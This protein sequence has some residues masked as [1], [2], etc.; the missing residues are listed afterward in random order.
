GAAG[1]AADRSLVVALGI[2]ALLVALALALAWRWRA[3]SAC[4]TAQRYRAVHELLDPERLEARLRGALHDVASASASGEFDDSALAALVAARVAGLLDAAAASVVRFDGDQLT[5]IGSCAP[6][7]TPERLPALVPSVAGQVAST[8]KRAR[9]DDF[10]AVDGEVARFAVAHGITCMVAVPLRMHGRLW[11]CVGAATVTPGGLTTDAQALLDRFATAVS[12]SLAAAEARRQLQDEARVERAL[13]EV[14]AASS[15]GGLSEAEFAQLVCSQLAGLLDAT[16]TALQRIEGDKLTILGC[17]GKEPVASHLL[18][19]GPGVAARVAATGRFA[20]V[21]DHQSSGGEPAPSADGATCTIG[22]PVFVDGKL[23]GSLAAATARSG[24][25]AP[26]SEQWLERFAQLVC[27]ALGKAQAE[28][29]LRFRARLEETL[30]EVAVASAS[31]EL[32]ER[33]LA[34]LVGDRVMHLLGAAAS[35]VFRFD[36]EWITTLGYCGTASVPERVS[37]GEPSIVA[38]VARTGKPVREDDFAAID[39]RIASSVRE[40]DAVSLGIGVP[41]FVGGKLWG[42]ITAG[43]A[44]AEGF[45]PDTEQALERLAEL[46]SA[47]LANTQAQEQLRERAF[48][49]DSLQDGLVVLDCAGRIVEVNEPFSRMTGYGASELVGVSA[50]YPFST[51]ETGDELALT[52]AANAVERVLARKDT[53]VVRVAASVAELLD[54]SGQSTGRVAA[55][56]DVSESF[57]RARLERALRRVAIASAGGELDVQAL[58]DLAAAEVSELLDA[59]YAAIMRFDGPQLATVLG[60]SGDFPFPRSIAADDAG[61]V[62]AAVAS[63]GRA[64]RIDDY[65]AVDGEFAAVAVAYGVTGAV[66][67]PVRVDG[68]LWGCVGVMTSRAGGFPA[69]TEALL[70]RFAALVSVAF[71]NAQALRLRQTEARVERALREVTAASASGKHGARALFDL[72]AARVADLLDGAASVVVRFERGR[73]VVVGTHAP[74][75]LPDEQPLPELA[76]AS[77][78]AEN[79]RSARIGDDAK[80]HN[81]TLTAAATAAL[82]CRCAV[83]VPVHLRGELWGCIAVAS[84]QPDGLPAPAEQLLERFAALVSVALAQADTLATLQRQANTDGLT[85]LL[86]HRA[87]RERLH[88]ERRRAVRHGRP[89]ALVMFDLDGFKAV[90]DAHG[91]QAGDRVLETVA[92]TFA[93]CKR[94]GDVPARV[95]GDEFAVIAP[96][97]DAQDALALAERLRTAAAAALAELDLPVTLSAG[98]TDLGAAATTGDL[99]HLAD[100]ALYWAKH[101]GRNQ[102]VRYAPGAAHDLSEAQRQQ[103][104]QR[105]RTLTGLGA[106]V[107]AVDAKDACAPEHAQRVADISEALA[108]RLGWNPDRCARLREAA[109]LHDIGKIGVTDTILTKPGK[110][111]VHEYEQVKAHPLLGA[112]ITQDVLDEEQLRWL[113]SHHERPDGRGYPD[114]LTADSIPDGALL[115]GIADA[116]DAMTSGRSYQLARTTPEMLAEMRA[117][118]GTQFDEDLLDLLEG[119]ALGVQTAIDK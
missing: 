83:A 5:L 80:L 91:H 73:G 101:H 70:E 47:A 92:G 95:G 17:C 62:S 118:A 15:A 85:G 88:E 16:G 41:V 84:E 77:V 98:V 100:S 66:A 39:G 27:T 111:T 48:I 22:V 33:G 109:L 11:G 46:V 49:L 103:R 115:L 113:R 50:P 32:D 51:G 6:F 64:A 53:S 8:G 119:W 40:R 57:I 23:W 67:V 28:E 82:G 94:A 35:G 2:D 55:F 18:M 4:A 3:A 86:N 65:N 63:T 20:R 7:A 37:P 74:L 116:F 97:T 79:G 31:G 24:G 69:G 78:V 75:A 89:L 76:T 38:A 54:S 114:A 26:E 112:H 81:G 21:D 45:P 108:V 105:A 61:T 68:T 25:F 43:T 10:D 117:H 44:A 90:N 14:A 104:F 56:K 110:L 19:S 60:H 93:R 36:A 102:A 30:R 87:F 42:A 29:R 52:E 34:N 106:L 59:P 72:V 107:R 13:R 71:A 1:Q 9:V 58:A 99:F 96:D 12:S